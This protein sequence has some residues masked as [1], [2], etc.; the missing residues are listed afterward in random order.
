MSAN[1]DD[2]E[3]VTLGSGFELSPDVS[4]DGRLLAFASRVGDD[5]LRELDLESPRAFTLGTG[6][7]DYFPVF[8]PTGGEVYFV[9]NRWGLTDVW[10]QRLVS[11]TPTG[12]P[13]RLFDQT[14]VKTHPSIS[15]DGRW[16]GVLPGTRDA[17]RRVGGA[18]RR[19]APIQVTTD[20]NSYHPSWAPDASAIVF[21]SERY[22][23]EHL[24]TQPLVDGH[25]A[26][27]ATIISDGWTRF[28]RFPAWSPDGSTVAFITSGSAGSQEVAVVPSAGGRARLVTTG[29]HAARAR[30]SR[31]TGRLVV[32]GLWGGSE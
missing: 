12:S 19:G 9:A 5:D 17:T 23:A 18:D 16:L 30:W 21:V 29:A 28:R 13:E 2:R 32:S 31:S 7:D 24:W 15:P 1:G 14:G 20:G 27:P 11:A 22:D 8:G 6:S 10:K 26:A 4:R 25:P 3:R